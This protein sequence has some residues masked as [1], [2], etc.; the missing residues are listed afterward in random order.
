MTFAHAISRAASLLAPALL[1]VACGAKVTVANSTGSGGSGTTGTGGGPAMTATSASGT[2]GNGACVGLSE[3]NCLQAPKAC[4]PVYDD[5]CCPT[6]DAVGGCADCI[7]LRFHHCAPIGEVCT[8]KPTCGV[9]P[10]WAC[11]GGKA[12][13]AIDPGGSATPC[14]TVAGCTAAFCETDV[15]CDVDPVCHPV[16]AAMCGILCDQP[17]PPCPM[18]T[19]PEGDG[20]CYTGSCIA[21][22]LCNGP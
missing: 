20:S 5:H 21:F 4:A 18:G 6:C 15:T 9:V 1:L 14:H 8:G 3:I 17:P 7:D 22:E 12:D 13:C 11:N 16:T 19:Y 10:A 2:G